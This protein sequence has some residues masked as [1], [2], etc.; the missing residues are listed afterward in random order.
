[1]TVQLTSSEQLSLVSSFVEA[2]QFLADIELQEYFSMDRNERLDVVKG[3][4]QKVIKKINASSDLREEF[5]EVT[6]GTIQG[7]LGTIEISRDKTNMDMAAQKTML[8]LSEETLQI[9][10]FN[11]AIRQGHLPDNYSFGPAN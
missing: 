2:S 10:M 9:A 8:R 7:I 6:I 4:T 5:R 1:M 3:T 11:H